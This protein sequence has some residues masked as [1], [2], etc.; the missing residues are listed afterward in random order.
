MII[1]NYPSLKDYNNN[2]SLLKEKMT[3][4]ISK[5]GSVCS[6]TFQS[7]VKFNLKISF[8]RPSCYAYFAMEHTLPYNFDQLHIKIKY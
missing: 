8:Y 7:G 5:L 2:Y 4:I 6:S 1:Y 3:R